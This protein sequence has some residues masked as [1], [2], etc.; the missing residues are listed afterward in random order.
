LHRLSNTLMLGYLAR[1]AYDKSSCRLG[2]VHLF[3]RR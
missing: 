2:F 3:A 1:G